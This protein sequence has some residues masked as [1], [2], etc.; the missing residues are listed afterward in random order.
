MDDHTLIDALRSA[1]LRHDPVPAS[2]LR[3]A[4]GAL[5]WRSVDAELAELLSD[6]AYEVEQLAG[7]RSTALPRLVVFEAGDIEVEMEIEEESGDR[8]LLG[9]LAPAEVATIIVEQ[10]AGEYHRGTSDALGR[11]S[12]PAPAGP[13]RLRIERAH[14]AVVITPIIP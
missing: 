5:A 2:A 10:P 1:A 3:V 9:Q 6:S 8:R 12:L 11:F 13:F 4:H 7:V 14:G